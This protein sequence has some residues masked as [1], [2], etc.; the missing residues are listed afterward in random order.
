MVKE[1]LVGSSR[2][3]R[4]KKAFKKSQ[5]RPGKGAYDVAGVSKKL[6]V[7]E[8]TVRRMINRKELRVSRTCGDSGR[9]VISRQAL[10]EFLGDRPQDE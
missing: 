5:S 6:G 2:K 4:S 8:S 1:A 7:S 3:K 9:I 10:D